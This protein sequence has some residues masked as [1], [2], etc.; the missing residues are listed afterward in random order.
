MASRREELVSA[1]LAKARHDL[2][3]ARLLI[4]DQQRLFDIATFHCHQAAEKSLKA[5]LTGHDTIF[6]KTRS[7]EELVALCVQSLPAFEQFTVHA[8]ELTPL[9]TR[10]RYP[11]AMSEPTEALALHAL[12]LAEEIYAFCEE[13][14]G[15][16]R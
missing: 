9:A 10:F 4:Q 15:A 5:W 3:A 8:S 1:W 16:G 11:S 12:K 7:L 14:L 2:G 6:P 13:R